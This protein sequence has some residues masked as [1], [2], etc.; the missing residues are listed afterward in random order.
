MLLLSKTKANV[1]FATFLSIHRGTKL[2]RKRNP[3]NVSLSP[4][5]IAD[6]CQVSKTTV[7]RWIKDGILQSFRLPSGHY[8]VDREDFR[9]FLE[10][11]GIPI[12]E[13]LFGSKSEA[14]RR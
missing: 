9:G 14:E 7:M 13:E 1:P 6:Y 5:V 4:S 2:A 11:Y 3:H 12:K 8:R 10:R